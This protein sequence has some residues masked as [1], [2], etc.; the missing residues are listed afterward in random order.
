MDKLY[1]FELIKI[2]N[3][4]EDIKSYHFK[5]IGEGEFMWK[6]GQYLDWQFPHENAD[7]RGQRRW[8]SISSSPSEGE[9]V[10]SCRFSEDG[11]TLKQQIVNLK[12]GDKVQAKGPFGEFTLPEVNKPT[13]LIAG[14]IG[15]TPF[16]SILKQLE[17]DGKLNN[18]QLLYGNRSA[19]N[20]PFKHELDQLASDSGGFK[21]DYVYSPDRID[22]ELAEDLCDG[23]EG[24]QFMIS[25]LE[26]MVISIEESLIS[27]GVAKKDIRIDDFG[28]YDYHLEKPI[29]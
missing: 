29:F 20:V 24:K 8:F 4:T 27:A 2:T 15:I 22:A 17:S 5:Y 16:I 13:I 1:D 12:V 11:S 18:V 21:V 25:G 26:K 23:L 10:L 7:D 14:G 3:E 9:I 19:D 6:A 28:G